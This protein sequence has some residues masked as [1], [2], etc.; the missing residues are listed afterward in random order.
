MVV[1]PDN[2]AGI[3]EAIDWSRDG[4]TVLVKPGTYNETINFCGK[5]ILLVSSAGRDSTFIED[6]LGSG[7]I[8]A[9][10]SGEDTTSVIDGFTIRNAKERWGILCSSSSPIIRNC[11]ISHMDWTEATSGWGGNIHCGFCGAKIRNN[12]V[13]H[14]HRGSHDEGGGIFISSSSPD[15]LEIIGNEIYANDGR[16]GS[17]IRLFRTDY[18]VIIAGNVIFGNVGDHRRAAGIYGHGGSGTLIMV[19]NTIC[20]NS[21]GIYLDYISA[22][23]RNNVVADNT[24][25]GIYRFAGA[26][27]GYDY[28]NVWNNGSHNE[29]GPNGISKDPLLFPDYTLSAISPCIDRGDPDPQYNDPDGSRN[30]IG[31]YCLPEYLCGDINNDGQVNV[32]DIT[33]LFLLGEQPLHFVAADCNCDAIVNISDIVY[34]V[35]YLFSGGPKPC[36]ECR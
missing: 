27:S 3:Q 33:S 19:N 14:N 24:D 31:A 26:E 28:N 36:A 2:I 16:Y 18:P 30:D 4:D 12:R 23:I 9:F 15:T 6:S 8:V 32:T 7:A 29:P 34:L 35:H 21:S 10:S 17:G 13:H 25:R 11:D 5:G 20:S 22:V 1:V